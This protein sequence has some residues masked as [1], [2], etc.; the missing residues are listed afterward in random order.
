MSFSSTD[1]DSDE[2][3][4]VPP[5]AR[6]A[7]FSRDRS[8]GVV[9][10]VSRTCDAGVHRGDGVDERPGRRGDPAEVAEEV[11]RRALG[12]DDRAHRPA[13]RRDDVAG[14]EQ[15]PVVAL[16]GDL[17]ARIDLRERLARTGLAGEHAGLARDDRRARG[18]A[19]VEQRRR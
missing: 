17:E 12:G 8:P 2:R 9:L 18:R 5:P 4:F 11:E 15:V 13:D 6:T 14:R 7:A 3:W 10:R 16:E 19:L 1:S